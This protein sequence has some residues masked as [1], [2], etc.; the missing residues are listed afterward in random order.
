MG[1]VGTPI[2]GGPRPSRAHRRAHPTYTLNCEEPQKSRDVH[3]KLHI[4]SNGG[5]EGTESATTTELRLTAGEANRRN[6]KIG[7]E[8]F[9]EGLDDAPPSAPVCVGARRSSYN[10][11]WQRDQYTA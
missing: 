7:N 6:L 2:I 4:G 10:A 1:S 3:V 9:G 5:Y 11:P 8:E